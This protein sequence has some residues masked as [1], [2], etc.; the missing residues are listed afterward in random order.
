MTQI[1]EENGISMDF[2]N[3]ICPVYSALEIY[4]KWAKDS[5]C[6]VPRLKRYEERYPPA[7]YGDVVNDKNRESVRALDEIVDKINSFLSSGSKKLEDYVP[8]IQ[9][10]ERIVLGSVERTA[11]MEN[12]ERENEKSI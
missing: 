8:L 4:Y 10:T 12:W 7:K 1:N 2:I 9:E 6:K 11:G 3:E 5:F